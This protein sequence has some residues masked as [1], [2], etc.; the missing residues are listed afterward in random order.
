MNIYS[1]AVQ[2]DFARYGQP[3][4]LRVVNAG[5]ISYWD[6]AMAALDQGIGSYV[7]LNIFVKIIPFEQLRLA[8]GE[9]MIIR[10]HD[11]VREQTLPAPDDAARWQNVVYSTSVAAEVDLADFWDA[12][13][14]TVAAETRAKIA[15]LDLPAPADDLT[16]LR[17]PNA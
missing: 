7:D 1:L 6:D 3:P 12:W 11:V 5:G 10:W 15:A 14:V 9:E 13:G 16:A 2:R 17:E 4:R 8:Y